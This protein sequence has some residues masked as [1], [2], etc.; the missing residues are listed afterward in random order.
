MDR[1]LLDANIKTQAKQV[2][3]SEYQTKWNTRLDLFGQISSTLIV[4][5]CVIG[6]V[7]LAKDSPWVAGALVSMPIA[8]IIKAMWRNK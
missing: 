1:D 3:I 4:A 8:S 5:G 7:Y 6:A 2:E